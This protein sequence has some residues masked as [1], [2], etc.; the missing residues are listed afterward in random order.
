[1]KKSRFTEAQIMGVLRQAAH[2]V[3]RFVDGWSP[4]G[5]RAGHRRAGRRALRG[6]P[7]GDP[8]GVAPS[9]VTNSGW[10]QADM[11]P[12]IRY[13]ARIG[14]DF[15]RAEARP[16]RQPFWRS[17]SRCPD[18]EPATTPPSTPYIRRAIVV[19]QQRLAEREVLVTPH[20]PQ[21]IGWSGRVPAAEAWR[22]WTA[23]IRNVSVQHSSPPLR[24]G[25]YL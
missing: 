5:R 15:I 16:R 2:A 17:R 6:S 23:G 14:R 10:I 8:D 12:G 25:Q 13:Q 20:A 24:W 1:M 4:S 18:D 9:T 11:P 7:A 22:L 19:E 3:R 21:G